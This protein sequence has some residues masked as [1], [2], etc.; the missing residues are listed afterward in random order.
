MIKRWADNYPTAALRSLS[1]RWVVAA[2]MLAS[3]FLVAASPA[4]AAGP[5]H[6]RCTKGDVAMLAVAGPHIAKA[7]FSGS[8]SRLA[9]T[10]PRCQFRL[11]DDNDAEDAPD[12]PEIPHVFSVNDYFLAGLFLFDNRPVRERAAAIAD[13]EQV[14]IRFYFGPGNPGAKLREVPLKRVC[15]GYI[16]LPE[17]GGLNLWVHHY[18]IFEPGKLAPGTYRWRAVVNDFGEITISHGAV[19]IVAR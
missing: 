17:F 6:E 5:R 3:T 10:W 7:Y 2:S 18:A 8:R 14:V 1:V 19:T 16:V 4:H 13:F 12:N 11:Y 9:E 15:C